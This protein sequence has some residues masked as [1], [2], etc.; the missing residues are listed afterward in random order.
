METNTILLIVI[1]LWLVG[2]SAVLIWLIF[3]LRS[4]FKKESNSDFLKAFKKIQSIQQG[5]SDDITLINKKISG[6][7]ADGLKHI[8]NVGLVKFNPYGETGGD[9]S[10]SLTL[11]NGEK[12]G[13]II[14][15]L[16]SRQATRVY[17][18]GVAKGKSSIELS[19]EEEKSLKEAL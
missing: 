8:Q 4:L 11:L 9:H 7:E 19:K 12:D 18:K 13:I 17:V 10:F 5:N 2:L 1:C 3:R 16:H 14:T 6:L 15:S